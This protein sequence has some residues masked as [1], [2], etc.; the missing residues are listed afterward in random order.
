MGVGGFYA[1][2]HLFDF[3]LERQAALL[4]DSDP[5][6]I[7]DQMEMHHAREKKATMDTYW[8][9]GV[10]SLGTC[11]RWAFVELTDLY[12]SRTRSTAPSMWRQESRGREGG[13]DC[14]HL[15]VFYTHR[16]CRI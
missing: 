14:Q 7:Y 5:G 1:L 13:G 16:S 6:Y 12:V 2:V 9:P 10:N 4:T 15:A 8:V 3:A 11:S